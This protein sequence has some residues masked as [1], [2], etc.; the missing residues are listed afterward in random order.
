MTRRAR[1]SAI[2]V[3]LV[4][5][6]AT[7][8]FALLQG[9]T[10]HLEALA[11][12]WTLHLVAGG[13]RPLAIGPEIIVLPPH[14]YPFSALVTPAC[15]VLAS[16]LALVCLGALAASARSRSR[17]RELAALVAAVTIVIA[18]NVIR[19]AVVLWVGSVG[20]RGALVMFHDWVGAVFT[21]GYTLFG[22][23]LMLFLVLPRR[24]PTAAEAIA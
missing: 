16:V 3:I 8:G 14:G 18:G 9:P 11:T 7:A 13:R 12:A 21:F 19:M 1:R 17:S 24:A 20:G 2:R 10:R 4:L 5:V 15:S 6:A 23:I 22:Y